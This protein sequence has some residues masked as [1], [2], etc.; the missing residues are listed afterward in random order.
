MKKAQKR[1]TRRNLKCFTSVHVSLC[2]RAQTKEP[3]KLAENPLKIT[4]TT[5]KETANNNSKPKMQPSSNL[6]RRTTVQ[7]RLPL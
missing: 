4:T 1:K 6:P 5:R 7:Q 3:L 2:K